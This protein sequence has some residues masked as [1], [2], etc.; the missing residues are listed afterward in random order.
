MKKKCLACGVEKDLSVFEPYPYP[1]ADG[2][3]DETPI[4]PLLKKDCSGDAGDWRVVTVCHS[5]L[6]D[7]DA[8]MWISRNCWARL[9]PITPFAELPK[10]RC[11]MRVLQRFDE[12]HLPE[13]QRGV[14]FVHSGWTDPGYWP[15]HNLASEFQTRELDVV[16]LEIERLL[17]GS[18]T[19]LFGPAGFSPSHC[20]E[21]LWIRDGRVVTRAHVPTTPESVL[22][23]HTE[24]LFAEPHTP[25]P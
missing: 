17:P 21:V 19:E 1:D 11:R 16:Y 8:D 12:V 20:G 18:A 9:H 24:D 10:I 6:H 23:Q 14:I 25:Q 15:F 7:L 4:P 2:V 13:I 3:I 22:Q 5:C